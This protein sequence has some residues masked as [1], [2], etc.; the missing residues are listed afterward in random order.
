MCIQ[1]VYVVYI[2]MRNNLIYP[3]RAHMRIYRRHVKKGV[4]ASF[5]VCGYVVRYITALLSG[6]DTCYIAP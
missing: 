5:I 2:R 4:I 6:V 1:M 3:D